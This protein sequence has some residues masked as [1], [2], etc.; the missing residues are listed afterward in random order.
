MKRYTIVI[1]DKTHIIG[2]QEL[3]KDNYRVL[4]GGKVYEI[5][6]MSEEENDMDI[7]AMEVLVQQREKVALK[8]KQPEL[9][10]HTPRS[11]PPEM[12]SLQ[13]DEKTLPVELRSPMPGVIL[14]ISVPP[15]AM[16]KRGEQLMVLE[17]MK[18]KNPIRSPRDGVVDKILVQAG[19]S[20]NYDDLLVR[21]REG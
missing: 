19:Q 10:P 15:G 12:P 8:T 5:R 16:V 2:L 17:A 11:E 21:Y 18:M 9:L 13:A 4:T 1:G 14:E 3:E 6:V 7:P 20:V